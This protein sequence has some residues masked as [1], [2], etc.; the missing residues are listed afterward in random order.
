M[1]KQGLR[2]TEDKQPSKQLIES[3]EPVISLETSIRHILTAVR[4]YVLLDIGK[5]GVSA[6]IVSVHSGSEKSFCWNAD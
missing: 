3:F 2:R 4:Y 5:G 1:I 6:L